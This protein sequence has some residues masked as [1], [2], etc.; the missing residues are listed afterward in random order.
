MRVMELREPAQLSVTR[1]S[2]PSGRCPSR[3]GEIAL[4]VAATAVCRTDLQLVT[5]DLEARRL[6]IVPGHQVVGHVTAL[7]SG[8]T[9]WQVGDRAGV[10]WLGGADGTCAFCRSG[11]ENLCPRPRSPVGTATAAMPTR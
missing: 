2:L 8:V 11:R 6:P 10:T 3:P 5:G 9:D 4:R 7:G 1:W